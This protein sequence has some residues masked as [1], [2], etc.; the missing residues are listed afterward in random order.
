MIR[1]EKRSRFSKNETPRLIR[2][3]VGTPSIYNTTVVGGRYSMD[4]VP[5]YVVSVKLAMRAGLTP[6]CFAVREFVQSVSMYV[7]T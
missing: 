6:L 5:R 4:C 3:A 2:R 1:S 7:G